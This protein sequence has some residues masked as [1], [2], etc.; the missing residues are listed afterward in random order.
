MNKKKIA[1]P[2]FSDLSSYTK[3]HLTADAIA[4]ITVAILLIPQGMAYAYLAGMPPIYGLYGG[5]IPLI[6]Y[7]LFGTSRQLSIGPVAI[8]ALLVLAG[9]SQIAEPGTA[10]YIELTII[11]GLLIGILQMILGVFKL[12][13]LVNFISHPVLAGFTSAAAVIIFISQL[14]DVLGFSIP[15]FEHAYET[16]IYALKN[17]GDT[18]L[19][20]LAICLGAI[21]LM[22]L[23]RRIHK[24]IP[25]ALILF[26]N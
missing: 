23:L 13:F 9:V 5:L 18:N 10:Q 1:I 17:I 14:R 22:S 24:S 8:S 21:L 3:K 11:T 19:L 12:G 6:I 16:L 25:F 2:L 4:G 7:A 20:S 26:H 15:R